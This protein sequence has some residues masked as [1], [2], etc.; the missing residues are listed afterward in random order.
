[1]PSYFPY[2][3]SESSIN[4]PLII[5]IIG[6]ILAISALVTVFFILPNYAEKIL[7][8][9]FQ[10]EVNNLSNDPPLFDCISDTYNCG[11]FTTQVQ[12]QA[13]FIYC[14]Q[15]GLGDV[16]RLDADGNGKACESLD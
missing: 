10:R 15:K 1:M 8:N 9:R 16:Y 7:N 4:W 6:G 11:N 14:S 5:L 12:A 3:S 13:A 2:N